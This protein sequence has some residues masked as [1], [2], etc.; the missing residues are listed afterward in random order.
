MSVVKN[1]KHQHH[2]LSA[3]KNQVNKNQVQN[4]ITISEGDYKTILSTFFMLK[5]LRLS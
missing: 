5:S 3:P 1:Y 2:C 4:S